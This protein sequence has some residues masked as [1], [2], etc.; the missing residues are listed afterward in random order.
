MARALLVCLAF[1]ADA[2]LRGRTVTVRAVAIAALIILAVRQAVVYKHYA[3]HLIEPVEIA[4]TPEYKMARWV[5][6]HAQ[7]SRVFIGGRY[8][9]WTNVFTDVPQLAG[10][11]DPTNLNPLHSIA[12]F[13]IYFD[14]DGPRTVKWLKAL[15]VSE[16]GVADLNGHEYY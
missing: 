2:L 6:A 14:R 10:G 5:D 16:V 12:V 11:H 4:T 9:F 8:C 13:E 3:H 1:G 7:E 15:G